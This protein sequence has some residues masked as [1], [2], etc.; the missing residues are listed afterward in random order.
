M[1]AE[2]IALC[3]SLGDRTGTLYPLSKTAYIAV[4]QGDRDRGEAI[5]EHALGLAR[6][7]GDSWWAT[8]LILLLADLARERADNVRAAALCRES[9]ELSH[10]LR[11]MPHL[12]YALAGLARLDAADGRS[13]RAGTVWGA[14][15]A[16]EAEGHALVLDPDERAT[17]EAAV[18]E[19]V[20]ADFEAG[21]E[22]GR[23]LSLDEAVAFALAD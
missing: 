4:M 5:A 15:E 9:L 17:L 2:S 23:A 8:G 11:N 10:E 18:L 7:V 16:L 3:E 12:I 21:R 13:R 14:V 6:E 22:A 19:N 1:A 20:D